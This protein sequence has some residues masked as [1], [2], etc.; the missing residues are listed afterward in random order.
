MS[1]L[2]IIALGDVV[3]RPGRRIV[4][5]LLPGLRERTGAEFVV[6]NAENAAGGSGITPD[7]AKELF[8]AGCD[9]LTGGDH[10]FD[11]KS[12]AELIEKDARVLR[13]ANW[14]RHAPGKGFGVFESA[15]GVKVAVASLM[16]RVFMGV[17]SESPFD[18][19]DELLEIVRKETPVAVMDFHAEATSEKIA[20]GRYID[21]RASLFFGTH[22]HVPTADEHVQKL[23]TAYV[24]DL[25]MTGPHDS[26]LGRDYQA[27]LSK[28]RSG[29]PARFQVAKGDVRL[30]G[31][32]V[33]VDPE[34]G[35]ARSI[36][37]IEE[38]VG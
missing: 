20:L 33:T 10:F 8:D 27:V 4:R 21:G 22:T 37:R 18:A 5:E 28:M 26:I 13:P 31:V 38:R 29:V 6:A 35:R 24:S 1:S 34:S 32:L 14:S 25:G 36:E 12:V 17:P 23:G 7:T 30:Q 16:G 19:A 15:G 9:C 3:G 11:Q 2:R